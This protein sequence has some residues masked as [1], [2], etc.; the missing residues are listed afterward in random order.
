MTVDAARGQSRTA[1][2]SIGAAAV[3]VALKLGTGLATGSLG[4]VSAGIESSGD[5]VAAIFTYF[6]IRLGGRPADTDHPYGH[7]R[8]ENLGALG[9]AAILLGGA[10]YIFLEAIRQLAG[11]TSS[12]KAEWYVFAV[13]GVAMLVDLSRILVSMRTAHRYH[14]AAL[15]SNA[16]HFAGDMAGSIAVLCGLVAVS[17]G[18]E[19]GDAIAA[20][21][22]ACIIVAAAARLIYENARV[23]MDT[24]PAAAHARA[25]HAIQDLGDAIELRRLRVRESGGHYFADAVVAVP[26]GQAVVESH[27][28]ADAVEAAVRGALGDT[29]VVVHLEPRR[30]GLD[31]RD[32]TLAVALAEP[33]VREAHDITIYEHDRHVS[34]SLHLKMA[35]DV[36]LRD[37]HDVAERVE[38]A[39][40]AEPGVDEVHTH[41]E[42]LEQPVAARRSREAATPVEGERERIRRLVVHRTGQ[43]P[44][45]LRLL[46]AAG[47]LVVFVDVAAT[48]DMSLADAHELASRLEDDIREGR[49]HMQDV[50]V[51]TEP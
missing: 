39:L 12:L 14:S 3:L 29:D 7:R 25:E 21:V 24:A 10:N 6:A 47:G 2:V 27:G 42:P 43:L 23:L 41:L 5:V 31:L 51:H 35:A 36:T 19:A 20:I 34:I 37:A 50:V 13:I 48:A 8:A 1:L 46:H 44:R 16:F 4:L 28:T 30:E 22:V 17:A 32:R 49:P 11:G 33:L 15:R 45:G 18:F 40:R 9:E 26:P 38:A